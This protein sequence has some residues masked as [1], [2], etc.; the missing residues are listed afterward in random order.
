MKEDL[1]SKNADLIIFIDNNG[2]SFNNGAIYR[3]AH[4]PPHSI[5][6]GKSHIQCSGMISSVNKLP[7][8][9]TLL[10]ILRI[11]LKYT[12]FSSLMASGFSWNQPALTT[13]A[14]CSNM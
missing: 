2:I 5:F 7:C 14:G 4:A 8:N 11:P 3:L 13:E 9:D 12:N 10:T 6:K 1:L